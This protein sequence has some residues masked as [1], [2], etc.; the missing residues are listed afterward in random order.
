MFKKSYWLMLILALSLVLSAC[1]GGASQMASTEA[2]M[3]GQNEAMMEETPTAMMEEM[4]NDNAMMEVT[5]TAMMGEM[6]NDNA[7]MEV[8]PTTMM[9]EMQNDNAM[10]EAPAFFKASLTEATTGESFSI[11]DFQGKV[12][13][14]ETM[15]MWC[16]TCLR[17]Q[18]EV[19]KLH[20]QLGDQ[21]DLVSLG[22]DVDPNEVLK[23]LTDYVAHNGFDWKFAVAPANVA[24]E[25]AQLYGD[26][27]LNP[28][29]TPM[30]IIDRHG[31]VHPLPFGVK[32]AEDL[33]KALEPF[34]NE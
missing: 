34:L 22:L 27:F 28:P 32:N 9:E 26:Q 10:M 21:E 15:A 17:Q 18:Q 1:A 30:M 3:Q 8:T 6:Q 13:L 12:V 19:V 20:A 16:P 29:S 7:M 24:R 4:Q 23:D 31:A 5:P 2:A 14:L 11:Q 25:I 33:Q